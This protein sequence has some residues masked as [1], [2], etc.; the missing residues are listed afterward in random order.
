[1]IT[2]DLTVEEKQFIVSVKEGVPRW[3]LIGIEGV[4]NLPAVKWKLLNI[5]R[6]SPSKHKKAV[7]KLR[8]YLEI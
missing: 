8:D 5:G 1:M 6:M 4:E 3:D 7:R 2:G